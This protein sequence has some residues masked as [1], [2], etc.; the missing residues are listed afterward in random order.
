MVQAT[1]AA[2]FVTTFGLIKKIITDLLSEMLNEAK[3]LRPR[4]RP[5]L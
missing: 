5:G 4:P 3:I 1:Y 2:N